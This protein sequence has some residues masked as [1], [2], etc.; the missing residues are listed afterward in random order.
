MAGLRRLSG[1]F[2]TDAGL[3]R[4]RLPGVL[5]VSLCGLLA[6]VAAAA[7]A[8]STAEKTA[9]GPIA[10]RSYQL[11]VPSELAGSGIDPEVEVRVEI[12]AAGAVAQVDVLAID[13]PSE[14]DDLLRAHVESRVA[15]WR[16]GPARDADDNPLASTLS[17]RMKFESP[18]ERRNRPA[19]GPGRID[20]QLRVL[21]GTGSLPLRTRPQTWEQRGRTLNRAVEAAEKHINR[22]HRK[23]RET[24]RFILISDAEDEAQIDTL[25]GNMEAVFQ[26]FHQLFDAHVEP[27][28]D[29]FKIVVYLYSRQ[30]SLQGLQTELRGTGFG[31]GFYRSPGFMAFH[32]EVED[33]DYLLHTMLHEA[34]HAF[35]DSH[36]TAP[37][38]E[39][40]RWAEEGLAEYFGNSKIEKGRLI[41]G[42]TSHGKYV[43]FHAGPVRR[44]RSRA[45]WSLLEARSAL[46]SG[47]APTVAGLLE[48]GRDTFYGER[49]QQYYGFSWL[50]THFLHHGREEWETE[51][52]FAAML[53]YM[54]EGYSGRDALAATFQVTPE[55]LQAEF[56]RYVRKF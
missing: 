24:P 56:E 3:N 26:L 50:L 11:L 40:P 32:Q 36:L 13:P 41:P 6:G 48:A 54:A 9:T 47:D 8:Q 43:I 42:K 5:A 4:A 16:Y 10:I 52:P 12:D 33:S 39:L 17:W 19:D 1:S 37:G 28:P 2:F 14:F 18:E 21:V 22:D 35:R 55:E 51:T 30:E 34:F 23:R 45:N 31:S 38:K 46:R 25:A 27:F 44:L 20:P 49:H 53:L 15:G 7:A 29:N